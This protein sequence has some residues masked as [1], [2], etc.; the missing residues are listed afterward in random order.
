MEQLARRAVFVLFPLFWI[1]VETDCLR[2]L[3][4]VHQSYDVLAALAV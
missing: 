4:P 3:H 2:G 1:V